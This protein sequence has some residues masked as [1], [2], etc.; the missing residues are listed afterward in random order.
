MD[1]VAC[2]YI[3][4]PV[5]TDYFLCNRFEDISCERLDEEAVGALEAHCQTLVQQ[6][7]SPSLQ[8]GV[9]V[10]ENILM[11]TENISRILLFYG[12]W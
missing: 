10:D 11:Y 2:H 1:I 12:L 6:L 8:N 7:S 5:M 9:E 3:W 4:S